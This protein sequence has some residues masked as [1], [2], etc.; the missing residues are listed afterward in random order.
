M[1]GGATSLSLE[2]VEQA[3]VISNE[4]LLFLL[5]KYVFHLLTSARV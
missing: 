1:L 5:K 2:L 4:E 3:A